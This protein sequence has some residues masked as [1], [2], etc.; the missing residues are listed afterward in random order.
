MNGDGRKGRRSWE[1]ATSNVW[2]RIRTMN[3]TERGCV[4][5]GPVSI[6]MHRLEH[7][8]QHVDCTSQVTILLAALTRTFKNH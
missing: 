2:A 6:Y 3:V 1:A 7:Q 8:P 5:T 4:R